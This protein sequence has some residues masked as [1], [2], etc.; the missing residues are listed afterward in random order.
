MNV[1]LSIFQP[2]KTNESEEEE[3]EVED[4]E[5]DYGSDSDNYEDIKPSTKR[6]S[7]NTHQKD[8]KRS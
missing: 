6:K 1:N 4:E 3:E 5:D 8:S 2:S 7:S